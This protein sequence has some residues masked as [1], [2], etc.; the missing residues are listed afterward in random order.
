MTAMKE[1]SKLSNDFTLGNC[2]KKYAISLACIMNLEFL[3]KLFFTQINYSCSLNLIMLWQVKCLAYCVS[4]LVKGFQSR[5][6]QFRTSSLGFS[7]IGHFLSRT[8]AQDISG[9][10]FQLRTQ[11]EQGINISRDQRDKLPAASFLKAYISLDCVDIS[12]LVQ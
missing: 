2:T 12:Y 4:Y 8:L 9:K 10:D 6:F 5:T 7:N 3:E 1:M 11:K